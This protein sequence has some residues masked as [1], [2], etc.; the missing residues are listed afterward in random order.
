MMSRVKLFIAAAT[1]ITAGGLLYKACKK[2]KTYPPIF[3]QSG[4]KETYSTR[5][6]PDSSLA[7]K[8]TI[9]VQQE[10][11]KVTNIKTVSDIAEATKMTESFIKQIIAYEGKRT[12]IS[13]DVGN[14]AIGYG[15]NL[16]PEEIKNKTYEG[17]T[18]GDIEIYTLLANDLNKAKAPVMGYSNLNFRKK[19]ALIDYVY[20]KGPDRLTA[21]L[22]AA[23][24]KG[25]FDTAASLINVNY[26]GKDPKN[27]LLGLCE[28]RLW[29]IYMFTEGKPGPKTLAAVKQLYKDGLECGKQENQNENVMKEYQTRVENW[30]KGYNLNSVSSKPY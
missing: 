26:W 4:P 7:T 19:Q 27:K 6:L 13:D 28:R 1:A 17:R 29:N 5:P 30:F 21:G 25:D 12:T 20:N 9:H 22:Q 16:T 2:N 24:E 15:H 18:L 14:Q 11:K 10:P 8:P 23:I 3:E